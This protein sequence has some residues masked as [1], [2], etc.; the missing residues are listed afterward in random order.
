MFVLIGVIPY[1]QI[2]NSKSP[3]AQAIF[4]ATH[5]VALEYIISVGA[6]IAT[7]NVDL[8]MILGLSRVVFAMARDNDLPKSLAK[9]NRY[10]APS[11]AIL[12]STIIM[13]LT[14]F[15]ISFKNIISFSNAA[16][17]TSYAIAN[18]AAIKLAFMRRKN[19]RSMLFGYRYFIAIPI[20]GFVLTLMLL[21]F[22]TKLSIILTFWTLIIIT[23]YY[24]LLR[25]ERERLGIKSV[26]KKGKKKR[27]W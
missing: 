9:I 16:A 7:I 24:V 5:N 15:T 20:L 21:S 6:M 4:Y 18:L 25:A 26:Y 8:A 1:S 10:G 27:N 12:F 3:L 11:T 19:K 2:D 17:L 23:F 22:L 14:I 13:I